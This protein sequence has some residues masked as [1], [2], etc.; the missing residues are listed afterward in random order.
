MRV[1]AIA[2]DVIS[3]MATDIASLIGIKVIGIMRAK[4]V[5]SRKNCGR[6]FFRFPSPICILYVECEGL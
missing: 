3:S 2:L 6:Q 4:I 5:K 1:I